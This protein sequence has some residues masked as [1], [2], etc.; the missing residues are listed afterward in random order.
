MFA[1]KEE[2]T[3]TCFNLKVGKAAL[4]ATTTTFA[5][6]WVVPAHADEQYKEDRAYCMSGRASEPRDLC[7]KEAAAAQ[8]ERQR[9]SH[10]TSHHKRASPKHAADK[11]SDK[12]VSK[13][14]TH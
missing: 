5:L 7:L 9:D 2:I 10:G 8:A 3:M 4:I 13:S 14:K 1:A 12:G 11:D 6:G